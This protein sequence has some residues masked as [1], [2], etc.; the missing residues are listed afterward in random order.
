MF[1]NG[2]P[3]FVTLSRDIKL[4]TIEYLPSR[5]KKQLH[6]SLQSVARL[7]RRGGFLIKMCLM[8][9]EFKPLEDISTDIP[10]NTTAAREHVGDVE[11]KIRV[12]KDRSRSTLS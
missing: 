2:L 7:Y 11:R 9:M 3:F 8:D 10:V 4:R 5:T 6:A 1:A 12:I